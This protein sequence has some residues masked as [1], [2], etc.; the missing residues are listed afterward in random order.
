MKRLLPLLLAAAAVL[1]GQGGPPQA[2]VQDLTHPSQVMGATREYRVYLPPDYAASKQR[3]PVVYWLHGFETSAEQDGINREIAA[4]VGQHPLIVVSTGPAETVG[5]F[6]LYL[7]ELIDHVDRTLRTIADRDHRGVTGYS[8]GGFMALWLGGKFPDLLSSASSFMGPTE[9]T[10]GPKGF[11]IE[12]NLDDYYGNYGGVRTRLVTGT[13]DFIRFYDRRLNGI[14]TYACDHHET[15]EFDAAHGAPGIA[16]TLDFH[17]QA[18]AHPLPK[19]AVFDHAD[20]YPNFTIWGWEVVSD[21]RRPGVT[22]LG[23]VSAAGFRSAVR[24]WI[25]GGAAI[26]EVKLSI[27][28]P[29]HMYTPRS[30][31]EIT[32][33]RLRDGKLR[34]AHAR[35]DAEGRLNFDLDGDE[36]EVGVGAG[37]V[38][39]L[40]GYRVEGASWATAGTPLKLAI[41]VTNKGGGRSEPQ[42]L[43]WQSPN[44]G[45]KFDSTASRLAGLAPGETATVPVAVTVADP[46]RTVLRMAAVAAG[47]HLPIVIPLFPPA[48]NTKDFQI[49][50]GRTLTVYQH[51]VHQEPTQLGEGNG[52]GHASPGENFAVL[53]PDGAAY[54]AAEVFT[55]SVCVDTTMRAS[56]SW[57]DYDHTGASAKF[58][59]PAIRQDCAPGTVIHMLARVVMPNAP[60]HQVKYWA[61]EFPVWWRNPSSKPER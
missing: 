44:P 55:D 33:L 61:I 8:A 46:A 60:D 47:A 51:A 18:F 5:E 57:G 2:T 21:R 9:Y 37:P 10:L 17:M 53:I 35:A 13:R 52:D 36:Y 25:P 14:W 31:H 42:T 16:K 15:E 32:Y 29:R 22:M 38:L 30:P 40:T 59:L 58:S 49:A 19:P 27:A 3:Y 6:P 11:D 34:H 50:D 24:E 48:E 4:Y 41:Q 12:T 39:A 43:Q 20:V 28:S 26:P 1:S 56:D 23:N 7:P 54:R 45:V